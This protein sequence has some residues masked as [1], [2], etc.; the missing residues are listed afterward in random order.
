MNSIIYRSVIVQSLMHIYNKV[1][2]INMEN[3]FYKL[4]LRVDSY[5]YSV[6]FKSVIEIGYGGSIDGK[7]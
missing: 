7:D 6:N 2:I 5:V 3:H 4:L 1:K